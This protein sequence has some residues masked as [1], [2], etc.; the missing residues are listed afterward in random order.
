MVF[1][2]R[3]KADTSDRTP[4]RLWPYYL[5]H[6]RDDGTV[7]YTFRQAQQCLSLFRSLAAGRGEV[8]QA[9]EDTFDRETEGG[10]RM[11]KYD[12]LLAAA[13]RNIAG[14]FRSSQL[15]ALSR[16]RQATLARP[17]DR[18]DGPGDFE[19]VTWLVIMEE[20]RSVD[21]AVSTDG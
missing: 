2:L 8:L 10:Q 16:D 19:L 7:R 14:T 13:L 5:V 21:D 12:G 18:P 9:L 1:C 11:A 20:W 17:S 15:T 6:V 4:N 3:H